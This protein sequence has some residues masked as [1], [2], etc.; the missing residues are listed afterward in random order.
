MEHMN[1]YNKNIDEPLYRP[2][3]SAK[4]WQTG[5]QIRVA[6]AVGMGVLLTSPFFIYIGF[7]IIPAAN[8]KYVDLL[9]QVKQQ[10]YVYGPPVVPTSAKDT[11]SE[12]PTLRQLGK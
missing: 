10:G 2:K 4:S 1:N 9:K 12:A 6:K 3:T 5:K 11:T 8:Q 7:W